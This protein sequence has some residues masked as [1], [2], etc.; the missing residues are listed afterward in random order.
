MPRFLASTFGNGKT[1]SPVNAAF[2]RKVPLDGDREGTE[3]AGRREEIESYHH[4][5]KYLAGTGGAGS[6]A[7]EERGLQSS[8]PRPYPFLPLSRSVASS[9][10]AGVSRAPPCPQFAQRTRGHVLLLVRSQMQ[11]FRAGCRA[12]PIPSQDPPSS[13]CTVP[14]GCSRAGNM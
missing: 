3:G 6:L 5:L 11:A 13:F 14:G 9:E 8:S 4:L 12:L 1:V 10:L 2:R 7:Q